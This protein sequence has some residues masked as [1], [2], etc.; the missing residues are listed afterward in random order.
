M[1]TAVQYSPTCPAGLWKSRCTGTGGGLAWTVMPDPPDLPQT[2]EE[3]RDLVPEWSWM[4][5]DRTKTR[6]MIAARNAVAAA[7]AELVAAVH[8]AYDGG[9]SWRTIGMALGISRQAAQRRFAA[10]GIGEEARLNAQGLK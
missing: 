10:H 9:D 4:A 6:R 3:L 7:E 5:R 8:E 2:Y 1:M